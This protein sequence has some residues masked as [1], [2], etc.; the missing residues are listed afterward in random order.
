MIVL[1]NFKKQKMNKIALIIILIFS[2]S[3]KSQTNIIE[4]QNRCDVDY[5]DTDNNTYLKDISNI[6]IPYVGVWKWSSGNREM[7]LTLIKQTKYH[8]QS[9]ITNYYEDRLVGYYVYKENGLT[10]IDTSGDDLTEGYGLKVN[11]D[12]DCGGSVV[13]SSFKDVKKDKDFIVGLEKISPT[14]MKF[15]GEVGEGTYHIGKYFSFG[16]GVYEAVN[17]NKNHHT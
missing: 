9:G 5:S 13:D 12:I 6:I 8:Y 2:I 1:Y 16:D 7:T 10:I 14:Q 3:C 4:I 17:G 15:S 11:F